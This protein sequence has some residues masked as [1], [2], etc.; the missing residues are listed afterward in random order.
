MEILK[1]NRT[2]ING[3]FLCSVLNNNEMYKSIRGSMG[4]AAITRLTIAKLN[5]IKVIVPPIELQEQFA[6]FVAKIDKS[7]SVIQKALDETQVLFDS[8]MQQ[9]FGYCSLTHPK[10]NLIWLLFSVATFSG[11][12]SFITFRLL[13]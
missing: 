9:Y 10:S 3:Y 5:E 2:I 1:Q 11:C 13:H 6:S 12:F 7:K 4:G 8:L